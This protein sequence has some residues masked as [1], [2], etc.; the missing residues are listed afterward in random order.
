MT[1]VP[2]PW[3]PTLVLAIVLAGDAAMSIRP[4]KFI[5]DCLDGVEFP[6]DWWWLL[7]VIKLLAAGGLVVGIWVP[8]VAFAANVGVVAYF[9]CATVAHVRARF[10]GREFWLNCLGMLLLASLALAVSL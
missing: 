3:W 8:G 5:R 6:R 1:L 2:D 10:L 9:I 4:P 7:V